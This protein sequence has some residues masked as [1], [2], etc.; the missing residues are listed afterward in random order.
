[1]NVRPPFIDERKGP[2]DHR[3]DLLDTFDKSTYLTGVERTKMN[4][5]FASHSPR[6]KQLINKGG[7]GGFDLGNKPQ[8]FY[9]IKQ[10]DKVLGRLDKNIIKF[11]GSTGKA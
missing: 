4:L 2:N 1:M 10:K 11:E 9:D 7:N 3:F 8:V 6:D 5:S